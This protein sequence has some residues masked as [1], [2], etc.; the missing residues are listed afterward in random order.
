MDFFSKMGMKTK[1]ILRAGLCLQHRSRLLLKKRV[2]MPKHLLCVTS[3]AVEMKRHKVI[4][5]DKVSVELVITK[6]Q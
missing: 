1:A 5:Q 4:V 3:E 2:S 6:A